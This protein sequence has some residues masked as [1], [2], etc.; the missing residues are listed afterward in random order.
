LGQ[1]AEASHHVRRADEALLKEFG[2]L[3]LNGGFRE[4]RR[5]GSVSSR[6]MSPQKHE[7]ATMK[8]Q[9]ARITRFT[10]LGFCAA[11]VAFSMPGEQRD[12][13][14]EAAPVAATPAEVHLAASAASGVGKVSAQLEPQGSDASHLAALDAET[15][16]LMVHER[17]LV[18]EVE[19]GD[20]VTLS[21]RL[22]A[23]ENNPVVKR[24]LFNEQLLFASRRDAFL[25]QV[26]TINRGKVLLEREIE[27]TQEKSAS[28]ERYAS[29]VRKQMAGV[30]TLVLKIDSFKS[31][32]LESI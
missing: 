18:A 20:A 15:T 1:T 26:D 30:S 25:V 17:R 13:A 23:Q 5:L 4:S 28:L 29:E 9:S 32:R 10:V 11:V 21:D 6:S 2:H 27:F 22:K 19:G 7:D 8:S 12:L 31:S 24:A 16:E 3:S 14:A